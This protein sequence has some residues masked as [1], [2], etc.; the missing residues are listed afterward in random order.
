MLTGDQQTEWEAFD[1]LEPVGGYKDDFRF[2]QLCDLIHILAAASGGQRVQSK[3]MDF[4]PWWQTQ[5]IK[6]L[7][8]SD[9]KQSV[10]YMKQNLLEWARQH[11]RA[12]VR[13]ARKQAEKG[14]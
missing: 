14:K 9:K 6:D 5:Y 8:E 10:E 4:M 1:E 12:E 3:I 11:N 2:A 13:K 7:G